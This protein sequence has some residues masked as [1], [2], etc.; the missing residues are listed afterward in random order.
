MTAETSVTIAPIDPSSAFETAWRLCRKA[1]TKIGE[2]RKSVPKQEFIT[3]YNIFIE[4]LPV[5]KEWHDAGDIRESADLLWE[6]CDK[7]IL[8]NAGL[9]GFYVSESYEKL[10]EVIRTFGK[11]LLGQE[12]W[13][14][15]V[16][17]VRTLEQHFWAMLAHEGEVNSQQL[18]ALAT[19]EELVPTFTRIFAL[20]ADLTIAKGQQAETMRIRRATVYAAMAVY[21]AC[22]SLEKNRHRLYLPADMPEVAL[23]V[24]PA[25]KPATKQPMTKRGRRRKL[26]RE[27]AA[28]SD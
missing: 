11:G 19:S 1:L 3:E 6:F 14:S 21:R 16:N 10:S 27:L 18:Y 23:E 25:P 4:I 7:Y 8:S 24:K 15:L 22:R 28:D 26:E 12:E 13:N 9:I 2:D 20:Q 17:Q 5:I